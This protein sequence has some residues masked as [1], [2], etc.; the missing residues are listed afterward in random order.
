ML[1]DWEFK[2][3]THI[4]RE[5]KA[6][7]SDEDVVDHLARRGLVMSGLSETKEGKVFI[8]ARFTTWAGWRF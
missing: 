6:D 2:V 1:T 5:E 7:E 4:Y 8:P 3:L